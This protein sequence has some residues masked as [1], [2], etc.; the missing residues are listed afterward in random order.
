[1]NNRASS[2]EARRSARAHRPGRVLRLGEEPLTDDR[3]PTTVDERLALVA[4]LTRELWA[5]TRQPIPDYTRE[6]MPGKVI[7][8]R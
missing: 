3:D 1:M 7:R 2:P 4:Q 5:F 8:R 6:N